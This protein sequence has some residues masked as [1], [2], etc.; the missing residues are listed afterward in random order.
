MDK[1]T[2][3]EADKP[4]WLV[5]LHYSSLFRK[6]GSYNIFVFI[7]KINR[8]NTLCAKKPQRNKNIEEL[9]KSYKK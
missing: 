3:E 4:T 9:R 8:P 1:E 5:R 6:C 2:A 7:T